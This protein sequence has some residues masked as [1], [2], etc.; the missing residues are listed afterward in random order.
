MTFH[1]YDVDGNDVTNEKDW[2]I[3]KD[4]YVVY[5]ERGRLVEAE[6]HWFEI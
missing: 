1:V 5:L 2:M 6:D 3:T 4:G